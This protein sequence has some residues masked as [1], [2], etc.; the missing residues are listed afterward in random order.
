M[1]TPGRQ[2][3]PQTPMIPM[4]RRMDL[5]YDRL[6][7][8]A[9]EEAENIE[10][11]Q[12]RTLGR[13]INQMESMNLT[14]RGIR[15]QI[16][17]DV[18]AKRR[19]FREEAKI[20]KKDSDNLKG[21]QTNILSSL[22]GK[23]ALVAGG[24]GVAQV[25]SGNFGGAAQ[26]FGLAGALMAP[27]IIEFLTGSVVNVLALKGLIGNRGVGATNIGG[28]VRGASKL[29]NPLLITAALAASLLIPSLAQ[30]GQSGDQR[31]KEL[32]TKVIRGDQT[33]NKPDVTRF[34]NQLNR[35]DR[36]LSSISFDKKRTKEDTIDPEALED[37]KNQL[38]LK[39][40]EDKT[41]NNT[42]EV[43]PEGFMRGLTG[44][45]DF[46]TFNLFD[47]DKRGDGKNKEKEKNISL[48]EGN[49]N[50]DL[51]SNIE[52]DTI[53][54]DNLVIDDSTKISLVQNLS[55]NIMFRDQVSEIFESNED[56]ATDLLPNLDIAQMGS[57]IKGEISNN[58]IDLSSK[59][60]NK[61]PSGFVGQSVTPASVSV[62]TAFRTSGGFI[63]KFEAAS[64]LRTYGA[65]S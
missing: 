53:E 45:L 24:L 3:E 59:E 21:V 34:R 26:S 33:I 12:V 39:P 22:R 43:K 60:E 11:P 18:R 40:K 8:R 49:T 61:V 23:G 48:I 38:D 5:A 14:M 10:R 56:L 55:E 16:R 65:F 19:Y 9:T 32:A 37:K 17:E 54:G 62:N 31:R 64:S 52:G 36:I 6:L 57:Q 41:K 30:A 28:T 1:Q 29:R 25:A 47:F 7:Q 51:A 4:E 63:D 42:E 35:F 20:L 46:A 2:T 50:L 27:E 44:L 13:I 58:I 15:E